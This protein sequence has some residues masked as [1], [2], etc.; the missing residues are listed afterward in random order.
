MKINGEFVPPQAVID[1]RKPR[2]VG[3]GSLE[4]TPEGLVVS[5]RAFG[6]VS[7]GIFRL[8]AGCGFIVLFVAVL[9]CGG[10]M[11]WIG[12]VGATMMFSWLV[13]TVYG[14]RRGWITTV[15]VPWTYI[16]E[17]GTKDD[18]VAVFSGRALLVG[19]LVPSP[20]FFRPEGD[21][22]HLLRGLQARI[23]GDGSND[24]SGRDF[25]DV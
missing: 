1:A 5:A 3:E 2:L 21:P 8:Q 15:T 9:L 12:S 16:D 14:D 11:P 10:A 23:N 17:V 4:L 7:P 25:V 22:E 20:F 6:M 19:A 24:G 18:V 13:V